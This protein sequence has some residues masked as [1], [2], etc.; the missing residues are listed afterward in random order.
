MSGIES[1]IWTQ[2]HFIGGHPA[3]DLT[4]AVFTRHLPGDDNELLKTSKDVAN[5]LRCAGLATEAQAA[6]ISGISAS[7]LMKNIRD[8][9]EASF[10]LFDALAER[11]PPPADALGL[12]FDRAAQGLS[13][14][15]LALATVDASPRI[16]RAE[17]PEAVVGFLAALA[18]E[19][20]F[21]LPRERLRACPR[22][23]WLFIDTS[24]GG[25]RRWCSMQTC[26]NREKASRHH[27][28]H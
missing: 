4:N 3:L 9:R 25:K 11:N 6:A 18:I 8:V 13:T 17:N 24:R 28:R 22:C 12:L 23:G 27:Q 26:G 14:G 10:S 2:G 5:W 1:T 19:A 20:Y 7:V 21:T 16:A 15:Q